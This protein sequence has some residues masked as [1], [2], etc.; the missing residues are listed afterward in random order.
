MAKAQA[1][2]DLPNR[3]GSGRTSSRTVS[4]LHRSRGAAPAK[5]ASRRPLMAEYYAQ[6]TSAGL[7]ITEGANI[8][9]H[10]R[11]YALRRAPMMQP[12]SRGGG[13]GGAAM[14][15]LDPD[16]GRRRRALLRDQA[17]KATSNVKDVLDAG[18]RLKR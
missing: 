11:G 15:L 5:T 13:T 10:G 7:I 3:C 4:L 18:V 1:R 14:Y 12:K 6:R 9:P 16:R 8:S 17:A 2:R